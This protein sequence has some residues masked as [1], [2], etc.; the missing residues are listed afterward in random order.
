MPEVCEAAPLDRDHLPDRRLRVREAADAADPVE[1]GSLAVA[2]RG[3]AVRA[4][5][6]AGQRERER[7]HSEPPQDGLS[8]TVPFHTSVSSQS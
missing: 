4:T 2:A 7:G 3:E 6:A 5:S 1:L 8:V